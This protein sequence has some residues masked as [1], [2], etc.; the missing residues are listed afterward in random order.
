MPTNAERMDRIESKIDVHFVE[1]HPYANVKELRD[2]VFNN[3]IMKVSTLD[4]EHDIF[5]PQTNAKF[6]TVHDFMSHVQAIGS[7]GT[8]FSLKGEIQSYNTHLK[9][10]P[11]A[12][13]PALFTEII[14]QASTYFY[15]GGEFGE[16]K[17]ALLDGFDYEN[18]GV[19]DG[20]E[21]VDKKLVKKEEMVIE[22]FQTDVK[23]NHKSVKFKLIGLG[24]G[25]PT[26]G[27]KKP[28][29]KRSKSAPAGYGAL[30]EKKKD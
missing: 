4:A 1:E 13:W 5:D 27:T 24:K 14:G 29:Y 23:K 28:S 11:P 16:Q 10:M 30:E 20:Y 8:D 22:D 15:Q 9:T 7:R 3:Q 19:V 25:K 2:D 12:A 26:P 18:I 17:I 6:R 21:I